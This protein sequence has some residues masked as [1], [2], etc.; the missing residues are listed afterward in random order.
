MQM[1]LKRERKCN[2]FRQKTNEP[3][4]NKCKFIF[5]FSEVVHLHNVP[6]SERVSPSVRRSL[7]DSLHP[8][9]G[10]SCFPLASHWCLWE[11]N[12]LQSHGCHSAVTS[13]LQRIFN[14]E[15]RKK[16]HVSKSSNMTGCSSPSWRASETCKISLSGLHESCFITRYY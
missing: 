6:R 16:K 5:R 14:T 10:L 12:N 13:V 7:N 8:L 11:F 4:F 15:R 2:D 1:L 3:V 9:N